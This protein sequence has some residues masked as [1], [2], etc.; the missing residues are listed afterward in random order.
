MRIGTEID[1]RECPQPASPARLTIQF[2]IL[3]PF[4]RPAP[5]TGDYFKEEWLRH[6]DL[7]A[8]LLSFPAGKHDDQVD[9]LSGRKLRLEEFAFNLEKDAHRKPSVGI[10]LDL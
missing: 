2:R 9:A 6:A 5:E 10:P 8:E 7:R 1:C 3:R 4:L